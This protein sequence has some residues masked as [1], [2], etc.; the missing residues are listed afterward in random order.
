MKVFIKSLPDTMKVDKMNKKMVKQPDFLHFL[1]PRLFAPLEPEQIQ[2]LVCA[3]TVL[4][5]N[6]NPLISKEDKSDFKQ[7]TTT[8]FKNHAIQKNAHRD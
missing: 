3:H 4:T 7:Y 5:V 6:Q 1:F 2:S 8:N